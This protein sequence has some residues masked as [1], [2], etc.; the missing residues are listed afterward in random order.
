MLESLDKMLLAGL[1]ALSMTREKAE[2]IFE[3]YVRRG[4]AEKEARS[5]FVK[6]LLDSAERAR[7][8][9]E[10]V[11]DR[12]VEKTIR[13]LDLPSRQDLQRLEEKLDKL[14]KPDA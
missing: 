13:R 7:T 10:K 3:E 8:E 6:D 12:Q 1:G 11:V 2:K 14:L 9:L 5:G 4:Q